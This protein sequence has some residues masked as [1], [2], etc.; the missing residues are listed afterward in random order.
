MYLP[1]IDLNDT[2]IHES[3]RSGFAELRVSIYEVPANGRA[4]D[5]EETYFFIFRS[6]A[7]LCN[8]RMTVPQLGLAGHPISLDHC[9]LVPPHVLIRFEWTN[10][11]GQLATFGFSPRF[12]KGMARQ[13]GWFPEFLVK[14]LKG[15]FFSFDQRL[16]ALCRLLMEETKTG[17]QL[18]PLYFEALARAVAMG[19]LNQVHCQACAEMR[20]PGVNPSIWRAIQLLEERSAQKICIRELAAQVGLSPRHF[21][22]GFLKATGC[23]PHDY[24][25][26]L[27]LSRARELMSRPSQQICLK[28]IA[29]SCGFYDQTHFGR[30]F[31]RVFGTTPATFLR[32]Q[33]S[34]STIKQT[35]LVNRFKD[36]GVGFKSLR[37]GR[38]V[39]DVVRNVRNGIEDTG[40]EAL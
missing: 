10:A 24:L 7:D 1:T 40:T 12:F 17:C 18:G 8:T 16:E 22:R 13:S 21:A 34:P 20:T 9:L 25:L 32:A 14:R 39:P 29:G 30:H 6:R 26:R 36:N 23:A 31:R 37:D 11:A 19:V 3:K 28:E 2:R 27:R 4:T 38:N 5:Q 33:E 35:V 15:I